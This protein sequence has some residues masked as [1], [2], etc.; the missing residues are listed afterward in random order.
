MQPLQLLLALHRPRPLAVGVPQA[1]AP[2]GSSTDAPQPARRPDQLGQLV[3]QGETVLGPHQVL[4]KIMG[5]AVDAGMIAQSPCRRIPLPRVEREEMRFLD[6]AEVNRLAD[7]IDDRY[8]ALV[9]LGAYGGLRIGELAGLRRRRVDLLRSTVSVGPPKT[10][11]SRRVVGLPRRVVG[12]VEHHLGRHVANDPGAFLFTAPPG[13]TLRVSA[14]RAR[15]WRPATA[16]AGLESVRIHDL[17]HTAV[18]LWIAA[19][20]SPKEVAA[21]AGHT[22]VRVVLDTYCGLY[23]KQDTGLRGRLDAMIGGHHSIDAPVLPRP[24]LP[25]RAT[26]RPAGLLGSAAAAVGDQGL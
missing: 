22:S 4:A 19:G 2:S 26:C 8:R 14:F 3:D 15:I 18:A 20:A 10:R 1:G 6:P 24:A 7:A 5:A 13:R 11:A 16:A 21:R 23:P 25:W 17:R 9:L 12:E